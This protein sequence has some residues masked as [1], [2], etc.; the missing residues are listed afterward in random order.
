MIPGGNDQRTLRDSQ[1]AHVENR[2]RRSSDH[3][4]KRDKNDGQLLD[5]HADPGDESVQVFEFG[6]EPTVRR[7]WMFST[8]RDPTR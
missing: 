6:Q 7:V 2:L 4:A 5:V 1:S 3:S 8:P